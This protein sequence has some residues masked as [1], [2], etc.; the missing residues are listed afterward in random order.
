MSRQILALKGVRLCSR[1]IVEME[2]MGAAAAAVVVVV[3]VKI[4]LKLNINLRKRIG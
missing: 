1:Q 2:V 4:R 3:E